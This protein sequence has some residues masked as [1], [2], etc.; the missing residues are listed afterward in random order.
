[1]ENIGSIGEYP[2]KSH[3]LTLPLTQVETSSSNL[4]CNLF[5]YVWL[6]ETV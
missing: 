3:P 6:P 5:S 4:R 2:P 1:M